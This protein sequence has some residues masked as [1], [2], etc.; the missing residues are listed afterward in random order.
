MTRALVNVDLAPLAVETGSASAVV[1]AN[2]IDASS[3]IEALMAIAIVDVV[4]TLA[5]VKTFDTATGVVARCVLA[6]QRVSAQF[7]HRTLVH[8][9]IASVALPA[10]CALAAVAVLQVGAGRPVQTRRRQTFVHIDLASGSS[11]SWRTGTVK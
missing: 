1:L 7:G 3:A 5:T 6:T 9:L 10:V 4:L 8:I 2:Q 11:P